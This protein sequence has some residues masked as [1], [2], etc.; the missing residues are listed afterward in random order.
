M[1]KQNIRRGFTLI[2]LLVVVLI[3][4][5]LAAVAVPQ[6]QVAVLKSRFTQA[7][8][9]ASA[10]ANAQEVY[11]LSNGKYAESFEDLDVDTPA[12]QEE[13]FS[14]VGNFKRPTR[15][16]NKFQCTLWTNSDALSCVI[17][18]YQIRFEIF[19]KHSEG[20]AARG[21]LSYSTD[22]N[23]IGNKVC[24]TE[25]GLATPTETGDDYM[26]WVYP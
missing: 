19:F 18:N 26:R 2:E 1:K 9:L 21:C 10:L 15:K 6:Y 7:R 16:F 20:G 22:I 12:Y 17:F 25:T 13:T 23:E 4:G 14:Y 5:I 24:K 8:T 3:I 11:Y